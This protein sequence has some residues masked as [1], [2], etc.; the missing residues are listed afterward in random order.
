[1]SAA[2]ALRDDFDGPELRALAKASRDAAQV[3][4]LLRMDT[5][6]QIKAFRLSQGCDRL[7]H[8]YPDC[9]PTTPSAF[10]RI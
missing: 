7:E 2:I 8:V 4:R 6:T 9:I 10:K 5:E 3:R 1:M